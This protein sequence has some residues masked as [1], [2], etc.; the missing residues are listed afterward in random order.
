MQPESP[1]LTRLPR[2]LA[3]QLPEQRKTVLVLCFSFVS[4]LSGKGQP[5]QGLRQLQVQVEKT[6]QQ[7]APA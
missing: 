4:T 6:N 5:G 1:W 2:P 3:L 7:G